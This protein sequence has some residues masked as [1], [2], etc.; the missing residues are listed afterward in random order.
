M[1][2]KPKWTACTKFTER[3]LDDARGRSQMRA[4]GLERGRSRCREMLSRSPSR[5][6]SRSRSPSAGASGHRDRLSC[7]VSVMNLGGMRRASISLDYML[8][9]ILDAPAFILVILEMWDELYDAILSQT[10]FPWCAAREEQIAVF[11]KKPLAKCVNIIAYD[12]METPGSPGSTFALAEVQWDTWTVMKEPAFRLLAGHIHYKQAKKMEEFTDF[13]RALSRVVF[14]DSDDTWG[15]S[16]CTTTW[17][18]YP[19]VLCVDANMGLFGLPR[20]LELAGIQATLMAHHAEF[21]KNGTSNDLK[22]EAHPDSERGP[23]VL[24]SMGIFV[25]GMHEGFRSHGY[26]RKA[27]Q[28]AFRLIACYEVREYQS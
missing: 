12:K 7:T 3:A 16:G 6:K 13:A 25:L 28:G 23:L 24:D 26:A 18:K 22:W 27:L 15:L 19:R 5:G 20:E 11:A 21:P 9:A 8:S 4:V 14:R 2:P 17:C 1:G 10:S